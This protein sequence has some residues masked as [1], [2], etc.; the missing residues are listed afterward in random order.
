MIRDTQADAVYVPGTLRRGRTMPERLA[1]VLA[2]AEPLLG[3]DRARG[4]RGYVRKLESPDRRE[5]WLYVTADPDDTLL[6]PLTA[7]G[8]LRGRP[9]YDWVEG[10]DGVKLGYLVPAARELASP[11]FRPPG[12]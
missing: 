6:F 2:I 5:V 1:S 10:P 9:R 8:P 12:T 7:D 11:A 4:G 3:V